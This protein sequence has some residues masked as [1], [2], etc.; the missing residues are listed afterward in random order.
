MPDRQKAYSLAIQ[1]H[2]ELLA[3]EDTHPE[4]RQ[5]I[6]LSDLLAIEMGWDWVSDNA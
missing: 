4:L 3:L 1:L 2:Q 6:D 5:A